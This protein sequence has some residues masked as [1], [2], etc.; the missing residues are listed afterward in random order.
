MTTRPEPT[1]RA[2]RAD[3]SALGNVRRMLRRRRVP[4]DEGI[5]GPA[6]RDRRGARVTAGSSTSLAAALAVALLTG[7]GA[8]PAH[9]WTWV[10][11]VA[12]ACS[13]PY[14]DAS[15]WN[16]PIGDTPRYDAQSD[17][18]V[19][20][21]QGTFSSDPTQ[22]T[23]P[24]FEVAGSTPRRT[25]SL[26]GF[27]SNVTNG[28]LTLVNQRGG[29]VDLPIPENAVAAAGSDA[30]II[31]VD[32]STG[33][34]WGASHFTRTAF[35]ALTAWNV[36]HYNTR[37][38]GVPPRAANGGGF[39]NRGAGVTYLSGLVR[40]CE[41]AQGRIDHALAFAYDYPT[42]EFI[43]PAT[44]SDGNSTDPR[45]LPEGARLQ[46]DP[47]LSEAQIR[48]WG[49]SGPCLTIARALQDYG[50]YVIDNSGRPKTMLEYEGTAQWG[51]LVASKT[52]APIPLSAFKVLEL[53][54]GP[55]VAAPSSSSCTI[56]GTA[57]RD[58]LLGTARR[59]V[60]CGRG[61]NDVIRSGGGN[62]V[63]LGGAGDDLI[64][65]GPG[66][67]RLLGGTGRDTLIGGAG[68]DALF[69]EGGADSIL[70]VDRRAD[71]VSGGR[72]R[73]S[74]QVDRGLDRVRGVETIRRPPA[75]R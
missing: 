73:D 19:G 31:L 65:G 39:A 48:G 8:A 14:S 53:K 35:G 54:A 37:W 27:F 58:V 34:E 29:T 17:W 56:V 60:I 22:Y 32:P 21:L 45:D 36:Y 18:H 7:L 3:L 46:L 9:A 28:G 52:V 42:G 71:G 15:P 23:Y 66:A 10:A 26:S 24:V 61:G 16:T 40:P 44:K 51:G 69:G 4:S 64:H 1:D 67:D 30:Q 74:A 6:R 62:D 41:I 70:A 2:G 43:Y 11:D 5:A 72:G 68:R 38:I 75:V 59:D 63:V 25:V 57:R 12:T 50:M 49:C 33:D 55:P 47:R 20:A 13:R